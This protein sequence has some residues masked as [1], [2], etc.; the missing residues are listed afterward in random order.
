MR[1]YWL[2]NSNTK[3]YIKE[4]TKFSEQLNKTYYSIDFI[5]KTFT[6]ANIILQQKV[7][8][9]KVIVRSKQDEISKNKKKYL[10]Q[11]NIPSQKPTL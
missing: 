2:K 6:G 3:D 7:K 10:L 5:Q 1:Y 4:I 11:N 8:F 9:R